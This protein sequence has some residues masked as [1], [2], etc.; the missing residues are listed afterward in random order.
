MRPRLTAMAVLLGFVPPSAHAGVPLFE[1]R[2]SAFDLQV[3]GDLAGVPPGTVRYVRYS[4]LRALPATVL[5]VTGEF[6]PGEQDLTV[7]FL[8]DLAKELSANPGAD[9]VLASCVDRYA[10]VFPA[11]FI[12]RYRPFL[13]LAIDGAA[14][15]KWPPKGMDYNPGPYAIT[16]SEKLAPG[17]AGWIDL[18]HKRPWGVSGIEFAR[19]SARFADAY[20][21]RWSSLSPRAAAGRD[22]WINACDSCHLG[23]GR[24]F[25]G[26]QSRQA[27][28]IIAAIARGDPPLFKR[29]VRDPKSVI[30]TA[31]MEPHPNYTEA[32]LDS[33]IAFVEAERK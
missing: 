21:G 10:S 13:V 4:D 33:I 20:T 22:I 5:R 15:D 16:V 1:R 19:F 24:I 7:V 28:P 12:A 23:P 9:C 25:S 17:V 26:N 29:Y 32:Q 6:F 14:P 8:G 18:D 31:K 2:A 27:F 11:D 30:S 3:S